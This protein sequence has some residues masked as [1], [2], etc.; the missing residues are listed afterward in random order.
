MSNGNEDMTCIIET[1][2]L[3][4]RE[5]T[6]DDYPALCRILQDEKVMYAY[7]GA[8]SDKE[9][10]DWLQRQLARYGEWGY[11]LW[12]VVLKETG[13]MIG[14][15]GITRQIWNGQE[16]LEVGYL[17]Q[18]AYWHRGFATEAAQACI[19]YA[20][21][22]LHAGTVCSIIRDTNIASQHVAM[23][24][25]MKRACG[26]MVKHYRGAEMPHWLFTVRERNSGESPDRIKIR[27][28]RWT[29]PCGDMIIG[30]AEDRLCLCG[31]TEELH[32]GRTERRLK[33]MLKAEFQDCGTVCMSS[34]G[35]LPPDIPEVLRRTVLQLDEYFNGTRKTFDIPVLTAGTAFQKL[36]WEHLMEIP[37]GKTVSYGEVAKAIGCPGSARAVANANGANAI[38][39]IIPCHRVIGSDGSLAGYGGGRE[40]KRFLLN[41]ESSGHEF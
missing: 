11:G 27:T 4:L 2:R 26:V 36:V 38:S 8:F 35:S 22:E 15:C 29:S 28:V 9:S 41:L 30:S 39:V 5:M 24:C 10:M 32:P 23:R 19:G 16:M 40:T 33:T 21:R 13:E 31:W 7:N 12:A 14:Q 20:F 1:R 34:E 18:Y 37:Y 6:P 25:G 17:L 3:L